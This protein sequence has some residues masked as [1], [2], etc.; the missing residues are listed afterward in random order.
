[1]AKG[2]C[3]VSQ[4]AGQSRHKGR[5][6]AAKKELN[7]LAVFIRIGAKQ[8]EE[9]AGPPI[10]LVRRLFS[11]RSEIEVRQSLPRGRK[12]KGPLGHQGAPPPAVD[13]TVP[14]TSHFSRSSFL[15]PLKFWSLSRK[16][17]CHNPWC[18]LNFSQYNFKI[19][20][21]TLNFP[22]KCYDI[23]MFFL[24]KLHHDKNVFLTAISRIHRVDFSSRIIQSISDR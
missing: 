21:C 12:I 22:T 9:C 19:F 5:I 18:P 1:M 20:Y 17:V 11:L 3:R 2:L 15:A 14:M 6:E 7:Y 8:Q 4:P 24:R 10:R 13:P 23:T 16:T